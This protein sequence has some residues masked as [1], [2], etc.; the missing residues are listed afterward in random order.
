MEWSINSLPLDAAG[1]R[2]A[3]ATFRTMAPSVLRLERHTAFDATETLAFGA[4]VTI[5]RGSTI[6]FQGKVASVPKGGTAED[7]YQAVEVEDAWAEL[8]ATIYQETWGLGSGA[9]LQPKFVLGVLLNEDTNLFEYAD[10]GKTVRAVVEY[11]IEQGVALQVG[12]V[13]TGVNFIPADYANHSCSEVITLAL[14]QHPDWVPWIDHSTVP[15]TFNVTKIADM[16][17]VAMDVDGAGEVESFDVVRRDD[18]LPEAV[19]IVYEFATTIGDEVFRNIVVDKYPSGGPDGGPRVMQAHFPLAG[20][21]M[22]IQK[23]RVQ[24]RTLPTSAA[25]AK[26]WIKAKYPHLKDVADASFVVVGW[27]K[28]LAEDADEM[29]EPVNPNA[30]RLA[31]ASATDL[32]RELVRG[33]IEDWMRRKV[34]KVRITPRI[35]AVSS[36]TDAEKRAIRLG[37]PAVVVTATNAVTKLYKGISHWVMP[38][39]VPVGIAEQTYRAIHASMPHQG[40]VALAQQEAGAV[41]YHGKKVNLTGAA[42][43][44]AAMHAPVHTVDVDIERGMTVVS[45]GPVPHLAPADFIEMQRT[46][47]YRPVR[48]WTFEE[49]G[50]STLG[51]EAAAS[52]A[53]DTVAGFDGPTETFEPLAERLAL[54]FQ[55]LEIYKDGAD[56]KAKIGTGLVVGRNSKPSASPVMATVTVAETTVTVTAADAV[57][58]RVITN[59]WDLPTSASVVAASSEPTSVHAQPPGSSA[60]G[61]YHYRVADFEMVG[62]ELR[63]KNQYHVGILLH[64]PARNGRNLKMTVTPHS[65]NTHGVLRRMS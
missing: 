64:V 13:P 49:R 48:W 17:A 10:A 56:W 38:E 23:S 42:S 32:P 43:P 11:A 60:T 7:E 36:A 30:T 22:Q 19:R 53:G 12:T 54:G 27:E 29:P 65:E 50:S 52:S 47:R 41:R 46:L 28:T 26:A 1:V 63:L 45:F 3:G 16:A 14:K 25:A 61:D 31:V 18:L 59:V 35:R 21:Q 37:T 44:W 39:Q 57:Y 8:E 51:D 6:F 9:I 2:V 20:M 5:T 15:P 34:G 40:S 62:D 33:T 24:T 58:A 4:A 55:V